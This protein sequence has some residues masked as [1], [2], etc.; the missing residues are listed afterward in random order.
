MR[1][2][3]APIDR[4]MFKKIRT[5]KTQN[6]KYHPNISKNVIFKD[7]DRLITLQNQVL[8]ERIP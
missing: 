1:F 6:Y 3:V 7:T 8:D 5:I 2:W 4:L